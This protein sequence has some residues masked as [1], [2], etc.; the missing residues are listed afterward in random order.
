[1]ELDDQALEFGIDLS[2]DINM[3]AYVGAIDIIEKDNSI[4]YDLIRDNLIEINH[5]YT[6]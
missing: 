3:Y 6:I 5:D 2:A 1:M 4:L